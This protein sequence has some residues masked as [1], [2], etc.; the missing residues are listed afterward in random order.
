[1]KGFKI[2]SI[3]FSLILLAAGIIFFFVWGIYFARESNISSPRVFLVEKGEGFLEISENLEKEDLIKDKYALILYLILSRK[4]S[5][6]QAGTYSL[7]PS[8]SIYEI[9]EKISQG[10]TLKIKFTIPE[11]F[12]IVQVEERIKE[13]FGEGYQIIDIKAEGYKKYYEF[14]EK[15][16]DYFNLE[17]F[18]FPDTYEFELESNKNDIVNRMLGNFNSKLT[19]QLR[20]EIEKQ[21]KSVFE[22][23]KM[24]SLLEKE[25]KTLEDKKIVSGILWKRKSHGMLLQVD[26]TISYI[27]G[28]KTTQ[29]SKEETRIDSPYNTYKYPGLPLGP[30]CNPGLDSII[31]SVYPKESDFWFYLSTPEGK[32]IFS[33]TYEEHLIAREKYLK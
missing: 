6:L 23:V 4:F 30:I 32:T 17:G 11:G 27:T 8:M 12:N 19:P 13:S 2:F 7:D 18:L 26:A 1:M 33:K 25:V 10:D 16:P 14:L 22:I 29:V 24:A 15:V 28:K 3:S 21:E 20:E 31:A 5:S 9:A